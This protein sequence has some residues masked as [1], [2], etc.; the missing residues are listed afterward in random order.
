MKNQSE[1]KKDAKAAAKA[2]LDAQNAAAEKRGLE[3]KKAKEVAE[4]DETLLELP[5]GTQEIEP[6]K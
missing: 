6:E 5:E 4:S 3:L 1:E 2:E